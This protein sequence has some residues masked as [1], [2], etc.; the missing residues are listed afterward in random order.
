MS[1]ERA[2]SPTMAQEHVLSKSIKKSITYSKTT[3]KSAGLLACFVDVLLIHLA[4]ALASPM[5]RFCAG[6]CFVC[7][8]PAGYSL[9][10]EP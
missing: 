8:A 9:S 10:V 5:D 6:F 3:I 2:G 4:A 1:F 7:V